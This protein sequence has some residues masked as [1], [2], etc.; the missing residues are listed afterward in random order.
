[1]IKDLT[2]TAVPNCG[3]SWTKAESPA[4]ASRTTRAL[5][6]H[7][8]KTK[9]SEPKRLCQEEPTLQ[10]FDGFAAEETIECETE[11]HMTDAE[12]QTAY[13]SEATLVDH[14]TQ[15]ERRGLS[16]EDFRHDKD[17][18]RFYTG[19]DNISVFYDALASL[20]PAAHELTYLY[21][22]HRQLSVS[23]QF[24]LMLMKLRTNSV[25]FELSRK[26]MIPE[27]EVYNIF[28]TWV[29]FAALQWREIDIWASRDLVRFYSPRDFKS[30]FPATR[31]VF[32]GTECPVQKP[33]VPAA[34]QVTFSTYKNRNTAKCLL[35]CTPGGAIS[36]ISPAYAGTTSDRQIVE[37]GNIP[38]KCDPGD[39]IMADK[40]FDVQ[41]LFAP[42]DVTVNI[43]TFFKRK[44]KMSGK[45]VLHDRKISSKRVHIERLI[46]LGKTYKILQTPLNHSE[47]L[48]A[49]DIIYICYMLVNFRKCIVPRDA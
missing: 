2:D 13:V 9:A 26:F 28:V 36:Y 49:S 23:D 32:D 5:K 39:S 18:I 21:S 19:L 27:S 6:R 44:N 40:G 17:A 12:S 16:I 38:R 14:S 30:K 29:R 10:M 33:K 37:R 8:Q 45:T 3:F 46:G 20:G 11:H 25:N 42:S 22:T 4:A 43:P 48:L 15:S 24:F 35:G 31:A 7:H 47:S 34:Q 1:M 41:D